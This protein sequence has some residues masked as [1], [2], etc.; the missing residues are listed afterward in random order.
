MKKFVYNVTILSEQKRFTWT[1]M[2]LISNPDIH[3]SRLS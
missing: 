1:N 3:L 2:V